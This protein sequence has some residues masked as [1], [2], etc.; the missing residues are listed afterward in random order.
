MTELVLVVPQAAIAT[1][2]PLL[3]TT[4]ACS[5]F[6]VRRLQDGSKGFF[7]FDRPFHVPRPPG[8][9]IKEDE[10]RLT[11]CT[12]AGVE[13]AV[14]IVTVDPECRAQPIEERVE[15]GEP[16]TLVITG[17]THKLEFEYIRQVLVTEIV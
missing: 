1:C 16:E 7:L 4:G 2:M 10:C 15:E 11:Q 12:S 3:C 6:L 17:I 9:V 5:H 8:D 14:K 13:N